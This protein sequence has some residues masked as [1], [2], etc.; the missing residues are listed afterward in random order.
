MRYYVINLD[1]SVERWLSISESAEKNGIELT[2]IPAVDGR[3]IPQ[4]QWVDFDL[5]SF[6]FQNG[7]EP[8]PGEY[9]C[10]MSHIS[11]LRQFLDDGGP[12][13]VILEDDAIL[14]AEL[15]PCVAGLQTWFDGKAF[16]VRL[17]VHRMTGFERLGTLVAGCDVRLKLGQCWFGPNGS[18]A[19]YWLTR[20]AAENMLKT[21][22]PGSMPFDAFLERPWQHGTPSLMFHPPVLP[23][24]NPPFSE[25]LNTYTEGDLHK[26]PWYQRGGALL[27]RTVQLLMRLYH[28]AR[29]RRLPS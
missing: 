8:L 13:A 6:R 5:Q 23:R 1:R 2:R 7:R 12:S 16:L 29:Q 27:F 28:C 11:A 4:S 9:G 17:V 3:S 10:Y 20:A 15:R 14:N 18:A 25:L 19:A 21:A 24:P 22:L 26:Y